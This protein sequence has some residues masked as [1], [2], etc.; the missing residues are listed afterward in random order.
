MAKVASDA[1]RKRRTLLREWGG[2]YAGI[3]ASLSRSY[4]F[5]LLIG[6]LRSL[7]AVCSFWVLRC[8]NVALAFAAFP[9]PLLALCDRVRCGQSQAVKVWQWG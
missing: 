6:A 8:F 4:A 9:K 2:L 3:A 7:E 1:I 5:R